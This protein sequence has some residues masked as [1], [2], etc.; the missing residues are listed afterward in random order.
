MK[1]LLRVFLFAFAAGMGVGWFL[2]EQQRRREEQSARE[3]YANDP[4]L[5]AIRKEWAQEKQ[6]DRWLDSLEDKHA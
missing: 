2:G 5:A 4:E 1:T 3:A 6:I